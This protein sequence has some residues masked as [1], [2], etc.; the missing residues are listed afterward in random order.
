MAAFWLTPPP[1]M[2]F[3]TVTAALPEEATSDARMVIAI[4]L[5]LR[6]TV[7]ARGDPFQ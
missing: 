4:S 3:E 2:G 7:E 6:F 1:G 5:V